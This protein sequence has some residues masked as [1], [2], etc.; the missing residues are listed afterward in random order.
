LKAEL[1]E[2]QLVSEIGLW[3]DG[4]CRVRGNPQKARIPTAAWK[5]RATGSATF[6][7]FSTGLTGFLFLTGFKSGLTLLPFPYAG[8]C[9]K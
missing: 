8:K 6:R 4:K 9:E 3:P 2:S 1:C 7:T 5:S